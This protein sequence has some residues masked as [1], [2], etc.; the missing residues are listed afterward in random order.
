MR[1]VYTPISGIITCIGIPER[2]SRLSLIPQPTTNTWG[3][4]PSAWIHQLRDVVLRE[5]PMDVIARD[6]TVAATVVIEVAMTPQARHLGWG[7]R[8]LPLDVGGCCCGGMFGAIGDL[9]DS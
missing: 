2:I 4:C 1:S 9:I 3:L 6:T 8:P 5:M 7:R